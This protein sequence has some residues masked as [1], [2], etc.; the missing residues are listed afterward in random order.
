MRFPTEKSLFIRLWQMVFRRKL[1]I[2]SVFL[3]VVFS[4]MM[5]TFLITPKYEATMSILVSRDRVDPQISSSDKMPDMVQASISDEEFNSELELIKSNE[6]ITGAVVD[7][8]LVN[9]QAPK[10]DT[11]LSNLRQSLKE[12]L[13]GFFSS[14]RA[15]AKEETGDAG[16]QTA[17]NNFT[18]EKIASRVA[19]NLS[20]EPTKKSRIIK[21]SYT[22]TDPLR[23]KKT[24]EKIYQKYV[25]LHVEIN[26]NQQAGD[27]FN[28]QSDSFNQKL[29]QSTS[30]LKK[31]DVQNGVT[32]ADI[33]VQQE[34][35]LKQLYEAQAQINTASTEIGETEKRIASLKEKIAAQ[36]EQIQVGSVSK[37]VSALD[38]MKQ[39][40]IQLEQQRTQ[41]LQKYQPASRPV[42]ENEERIKQLKKALAEET[43]N[44]PQ[45]R[46]FA[47]NDLR[48][49]LESELYSAQTSLAALKEREK[50]LTT[51]AARLRADVALLNTR[52][53]ERENL[54][55]E[56][57]I[58]EEAYLLYQ[59]KARE[60][61]ISQVLNREKVMNFG[62]IDAPR[63][64]GEPKSPK[65]LLNL[66]VL[67]LVGGTAGFAAAIVL[68][69]LHPALSSGEDFDLI[70]SAHEIEERWE[71]PVLAIIPDLEASGSEMKL[72][73]QTNPPALPPPPTVRRK[74]YPL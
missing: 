50:N 54:Q 44:P 24:L 30:A 32:G 63:T 10:R 4:G 20:V 65:M 25:E 52:S 46:S 12:S 22:D 71:L 67:M 16:A 1:L 26:E 51:Q 36:P 7:L 73:S 49:R 14:P 34:L 61:E 39:E 8:D 33:K 47:L 68:D 6:V 42:R 48:R 70:G 41:L 19:S 40:L 59:K 58:N 23:A 37:Y 2:F 72:V 57:S 27:V 9:N 62:I 28:Q 56:R 13:Y 45:E 35:L 43:A 31:F 17:E 18:V 5:A 38:G 64:D 66:L 55:R 15:T 53:I 74:K 3:L 29:N 69:K 60:N 11:W 21:V